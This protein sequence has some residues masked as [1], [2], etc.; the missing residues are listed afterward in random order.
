MSRAVTW[1]R[2][3][4]MRMRRCCQGG[5]LR[6]RG[7]RKGPRNQE[8]MACARQY[9]IQKKKKRGLSTYSPQNATRIVAERKDAAKGANI[10]APANMK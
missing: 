10:I 2:G 6:C 7:R 1:E 4:M 3:R 8:P 9:R 5:S